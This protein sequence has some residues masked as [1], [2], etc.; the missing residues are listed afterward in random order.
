MGKIGVIELFEGT[1]TCL[2]ILSKKKKKNNQ[3]KSTYLKKCERKETEVDGE[4]NPRK[5][6]HR[7]K[8]LQHEVRAS[9]RPVKL[10]IH[11]QVAKPRLKRSFS[12]RE[13][14]SGT[15]CLQLEEANKPQT[16]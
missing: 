1:I 11:L 16:A 12:C 2:G 10:R 9:V 15:A 3:K 14:H 13:A 5:S 6:K 8:A 7:K 4:S